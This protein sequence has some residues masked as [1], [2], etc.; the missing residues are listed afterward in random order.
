MSW[1]I[2]MKRRD[3]DA[4]AGVLWVLTAG[5]AVP[6]LPQHSVSLHRDSAALCL[7]ARGHWGTGGCGRGWEI[8]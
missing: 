6:S 2:Q 8:R 5:P 7:G 1:K 3:L 4:T